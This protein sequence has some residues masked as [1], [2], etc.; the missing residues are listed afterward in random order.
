MSAKAP[1]HN[2]SGSIGNGQLFE[3]TTILLVGL[4]DER[5]KLAELVESLGGSVQVKAQRGAPPHVI[6]C[7]NTLDAVFRVRPA[8][9]S[10]LSA[11]LHH[12]VQQKN[13]HAPQSASRLPQHFQTPPHHPGAD[14][15]AAAPRPARRDQ[16]VAG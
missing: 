10:G 1:Q 2:S 9:A 5:A 4:G 12:A 7:G 14:T 16:G 15:Q 3:N 11:S 8:G 13:L 6:V